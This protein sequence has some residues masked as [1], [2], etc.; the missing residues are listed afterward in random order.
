MDCS[1]E[2][3]PV[4]RP[5]IEWDDIAGECAAEIEA[6][7]GLTQSPPWD[8][9]ERRRFPALAVPPL[10]ALAIAITAA[11]DA[12]MARLSPRLLLRGCCCCDCDLL[13]FGC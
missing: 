8:D 11:E 13:M 9:V 6:E 7:L 12:D 4:E 10:P 1:R 5:K 2:K 3:P